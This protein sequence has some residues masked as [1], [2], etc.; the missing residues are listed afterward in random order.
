MGIGSYS[1]RF[2][3]GKLDTQ[4]NQRCKFPFGSKSEGNRTPMSQLKE[5]RAEGAILPSSTFCSI[6]ASSGVDEAHPH[7]G[8][9]SAFLSLPV[10]DNLKHPHRHTDT[11]MFVTK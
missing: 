10:L 11:I 5:S 7:W 6:Q 3:V 2:A 8:R 1:Y 9:H 4:E